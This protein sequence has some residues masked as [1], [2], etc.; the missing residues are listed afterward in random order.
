MNRQEVSEGAVRVLAG[1]LEA[2]TGQQLANG[3]RWRVEVALRPLLLRYGAASLDD[4]A[5]RVVA[6]REPGLTDAVLDA[7]LNHETFFFRD[8]AAFQLLATSGLAR[9]HAARAT[10]RRLR[11]WSAGCSTGQECYT[12]AMLL[13]DQRDRWAGWSIEIL[14]TD[15]SAEAIAR[16]RTGRYSQFEIQRGLPVTQM[17][18][19]FDQRG[20]HWHADAALRAAVTFRVHNLLDVPPIGPFDVIL[21]RNVLLYFS[22]DVRRLVF[23]RLASAIAP[24]GLLMLGAGETA[25]GQTDCFVSDYECRGL[26]RPRVEVAPGGLGGAIGG[27]AHG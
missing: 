8:I 25:M 12:L 1:L 13:A 14:G 5:G 11:I 20:E 21:C 18:R 23:G 2:R 27:V 6:G 19:R 3:R 4:L 22:P 24:D 10:T 17:L 26:Y 15:L 9:L 7:M 16:A